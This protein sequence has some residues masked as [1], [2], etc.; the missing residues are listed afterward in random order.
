MVLHLNWDM[1]YKWG[2]TI[3]AYNDDAQCFKELDSIE[4]SNTTVNKNNEAIREY[5][6]YLRINN[7]QK[8]IIKIF[9]CIPTRYIYRDLK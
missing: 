1:T 4:L 8:K 2:G 7:K 6:W 3:N 9:N 5:D